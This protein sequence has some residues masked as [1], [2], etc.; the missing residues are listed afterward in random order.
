MPGYKN[1][2]KSTKMNKKQSKAPKYNSVTA[3]GKTNRKKK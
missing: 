3:Q 2:S 1:K